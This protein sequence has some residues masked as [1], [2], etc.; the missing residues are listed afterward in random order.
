MAVKRRKQ[1]DAD[2]VQMLARGFVE[3]DDNAKMFGGQASKLKAALLATIGEQA[4]PPDEDGHQWLELPEPIQS[5]TTTGK[6]ERRE[7]TVTGFQRQK[8]ST[9]FLD[10][11]KAEAWL[12][13]HKLWQ[14]CTTTVTVHEIDEQALWLLVMDEKFSREDIDALYGENVTYALVRVTE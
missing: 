12:K 5:H 11:E 13:K 4:D 10:H 3:T 9:R 1:L 6:G 8:R 14:E 2:D 7:E